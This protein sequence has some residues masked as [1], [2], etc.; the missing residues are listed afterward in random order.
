MSHFG[1]SDSIPASSSQLSVDA[2][3]SQVTG[4]L[5]HVLMHTL[6]PTQTSEEYVIVTDVSIGLNANT[7][8]G[9]TLT[10]GVS[11][12]DEGQS[13]GSIADTSTVAESGAS[14]DCTNDTGY[15]TRTISTSP[16][17]HTG[18]PNRNVTVRFYMK[19]NDTTNTTAMCSKNAVVNGKKARRVSN[20][21]GRT[22]RGAF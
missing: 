12:Q 17:P 7:V 13:E 5:S 3:K 15:T 2:V 6:T 21:W 16:F 14:S 19:T 11:V 10:G 9:V 22:F 8:L 4:A 1:F 18:K 20:L